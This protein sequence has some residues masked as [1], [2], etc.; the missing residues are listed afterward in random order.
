MKPARGAWMI[1]FACI[2]LLL[3]DRV[4]AEPMTYVYGYFSKTGDH[5]NYVFALIDEALT[6]TS[7]KWGPYVLHTIPEVPRNRQIRELETGAGSITF[8]VLG[9]AHDIGKHLRPI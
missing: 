7:A 2:A 9:T 3:A 5:D 4:R 1:C 8:A 6:R